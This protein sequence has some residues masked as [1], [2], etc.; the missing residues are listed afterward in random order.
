MATN[1]EKTLNALLSSS[2]KIE[3][4]LEKDENRITTTTEYFGND[5]T[6]GTE[7]TYTVPKHQSPQRPQLAPNPVINPHAREKHKT[8]DVDLPR[9][10]PGSR[11]FQK[12][13]QIQD[14]SKNRSESRPGS[15]SRSG[16]QIHTR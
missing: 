14:G 16:S 8:S 6:V 12:R 4:L 11:K 3:A 7:A 10:G 15:K 13:I 5:K 9:S 2:R 1:S